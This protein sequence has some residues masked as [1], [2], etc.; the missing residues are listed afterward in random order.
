MDVIPTPS[1]KEGQKV[2]YPGQGL[3]VIAK[4]EDG[5]YH[6]KFPRQAGTVYI[7]LGNERV[8]RPLSSLIEVSDFFQY[9]RAGRPGMASDWRSLHFEK[10]K[11]WAYAK[12]RKGTLQDLS[13][14]LRVLCVVGW[15]HQ[16][17][18]GEKQIFC[19]VK[20]LASEELAEIERRPEE[21]TK[22]VEEKISRYIEGCL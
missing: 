19:K 18:A 12:I 7:P 17:T 6:L 22:S 13:E 11:V 3:A 9:L 2:V 1:F 21:D 10:Q 15:S 8:M 14:V 16:L 4:I 20:E 5:K